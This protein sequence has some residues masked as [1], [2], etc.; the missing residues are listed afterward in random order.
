[1]AFEL[2]P[3]SSPTTARDGVQRAL[4]YVQLILHH[5]WAAR[6][7]TQPRLRYRANVAPTLQ[8]I[9]PRFLA[10]PI[11]PTVPSAYHRPR[12][13][14]ERTRPVQPAPPAASPP[15]LAGPRPPTAVSVG[16]ARGEGEQTSHARSRPLS[17]G[18]S[19]CPSPFPL[20]PHGLPAHA[21]IFSC[22]NRPPVPSPNHP[23]PCANTAPTST[24][25]V[26]PHLHQEP[27]RALA[28]TPISSTG[29][30]LSPPAPSQR[31][32]RAACRWPLDL[33]LMPNLQKS[34]TTSL[35]HSACTPSPFS[36]P[37]PLP[38]PIQP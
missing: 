12:A 28:R 5:P 27:S 6:R 30:R 35:N 24:V 34:H 13:E 7:I 15:M 37:T 18:D 21:R 20:S 4:H 22:T 23:L 3:P 19:I 29:R 25:A 33:P 16:R 14:S 36:L 10:H 9:G 26:V 1:M 31:P 32:P 8:M 2:C 17:Q 38:H 11:S